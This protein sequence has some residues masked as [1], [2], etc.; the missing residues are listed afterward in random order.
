M[1]RSCCPRPL[2]PP[3]LQDVGGVLQLVPQ[4][5]SQEPIGPATGRTGRA[6]VGVSATGE[7]VSVCWPASRAYVVYYRTL[8]ATWQQVDSGLGV[9]LAW[10]STK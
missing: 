4:V 9:D 7:Y 10:H 3:C 5:V 8:A 1:P 2:L 6:I